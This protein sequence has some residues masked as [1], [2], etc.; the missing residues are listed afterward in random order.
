MR[1]SRFRA[2]APTVS[3]PYPDTRVAEAIAAMLAN[4]QRPLILVGKGA[5]WADAAVRAHAAR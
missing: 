4:A 5:A 1:P 3:L 2:G